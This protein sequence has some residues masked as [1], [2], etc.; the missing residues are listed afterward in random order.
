[1]YGLI[2][3][4][5]VMEKQKSEVFKSVRDLNTYKKISFPPVLDH[6]MMYK[7]L[8]WDWFERIRVDPFWQ[9]QNV[10]VCEDCYLIIT[11]NTYSNDKR[12]Q[13]IRKEL[14]IPPMKTLL[15]KEHQR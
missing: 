2:K 6:Q 4:G 13:E 7:T 11:T 15:E 10:R 3:K 14:G 9:N 8:T 12:K 5:S 1:M